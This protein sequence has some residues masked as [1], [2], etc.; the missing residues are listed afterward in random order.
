MKIFLSLLILFFSIQSWTK[1]DDIRDFEIEGM[2]IG[3]S[4][5][6]Y[7]SKKQINKFFY[8]KSKKFAYSEHELY[9]SKNYEGFRFHYKL[10]D[11]EFI[12]QGMSGIIFY[13]NNFDAC[14]TKKKEIIKDIESSFPSGKRVDQGKLNH[15]S[16]PTGKSVYTYTGF[17]FKNGTISLEC[18]DWSN[19]ITSNRGWTDNL[20]VIIHTKELANWITYDA[21]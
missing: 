21:R 6:N 2:S 19:K 11:K 3:D 9:N 8:S 17:N 10:K 13:S 7:F 15:P 20:A 16:D 5:L 4:A 18:T 12:I 1:A 14:N